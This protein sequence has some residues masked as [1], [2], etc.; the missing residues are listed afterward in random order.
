MRGTFDRDILRAI[1]GEEMVCAFLRAKGYDAWRITNVAL[2]KHGADIIFDKRDGSPQQI[3][4]V[5]TDFK[6]VETKNIYWETEANGRPGW[7]LASEISRSYADWFCWVLGDD[8][9]WLTKRRTLKTAEKA[10][11][12]RHIIHR[13]GA[14]YVIPTRDVFLY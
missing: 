7:G 11:K 5:K 4:Q 3:V 10:H 2:Q 13:F 1:P 9:L 6:A 12:F 14:G 8:L